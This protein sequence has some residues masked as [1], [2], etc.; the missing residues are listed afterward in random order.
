MFMGELTRGVDIVTC[1]WMKRLS[2][3]KVTIT[4]VE[5][6]SD[7]QKRK[8]VSRDSDATGDRVGGQP[9]ALGWRKRWLDILSTQWRGKMSSG[10]FTQ[11]DA[12]ACGSRCREA[13]RWFSDKYLE[14]KA[15]RS[16]FKEERPGEERSSSWRGNYWWVNILYPW[17][18]LGETLLR[19]SLQ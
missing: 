10:S 6:E 8:D 7:A 4:L 15:V 16:D 1:E 5:N 14:K 17:N 13:R 3:D 12:V 2:G 11:R 18:I 9:E 19:S